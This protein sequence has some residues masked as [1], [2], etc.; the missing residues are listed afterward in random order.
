[1]ATL[2]WQDG[3]P[4]PAL[5]SLRRP[6]QGMGHRRSRRLA[7]STRFLPAYEAGLDVRFEGLFAGEKRRRVSLPSYPFPAR[8]VLG[9]A[10]KAAATERGTRAAGRAA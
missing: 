6:P 4:P 7:S 5:A 1:M 9:G 10:D 3:A 8:A 2:A